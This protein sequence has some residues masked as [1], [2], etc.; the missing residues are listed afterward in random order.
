MKKAKPA[1]IL[2]LKLLVSGGL[3]FF[4]F[5]KIHIERFFET[6]LAANFPFIA[7]AMAVY[8]LT[9]AIGTLRWQVQRHGLL[10]VPCDLVQRAPLGHDRD[11][12]ALGYVARLLTRANHRLDRVLKHACPPEDP[13]YSAS[14]E[15]QETTTGS[16]TLA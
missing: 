3:L 5:T 16:Y 14:S 2:L 12:E 7:L 13:Q 8:L 4:F 10:Q 1:L 11:L 15:A 6:L 9:Q